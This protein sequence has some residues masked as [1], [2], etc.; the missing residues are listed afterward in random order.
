MSN[1]TKSKSSNG[2]YNTD[3]NTKRIV[4][5]RAAGHCELCGIDLTRDFRAGK[6]MKWGEVAHILP[7]SPKGP[8]G[9]S[10]H[11]E[12]MAEVLTNDSK[13]LMLLCPNCHEKIDRDAEGY[14]E[15]DLNN[16]HQE[17]LERIK[18]AATTPENGRAIPIIVQ[19]HHFST[20]NDI[21]EDDLLSAMSAEGLA[22]FDE[23][24]KIDLTAPIGN[25]RDANYW[26]RHKQEIQDLLGNQLKRRG[27]RF[28]DPPELAVVGV[29][30]IPSLIM[31]GQSL[32]DRSKRSL[33]S[34][35]RG[36]RLKWPNLSAKPPE[37]QFTPPVDGDGPIALVLS[38][39]ALIPHR[40][41][42]AALSG[43]RIAEFRIPEPNYEMV[44]NRK[45]IHAFSHQLQICLSKLEAMSA[46]TIHVFPAIPAALAIEFG[47]L[48]TTQHQHP[49]QIFDRD[50]NKNN[51]F[52]VTLKLGSSSS[53]GDCQ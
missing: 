4:W 31:L 45:V 25:I 18:L 46:D 41:V 21:S 48:L 9:R 38:I 3:E 52:T 13:N 11:N 27:G 10:E 51:A 15:K 34:Y 33:F 2:R 7:A 40:D 36:H 42:E 28:G 17:H 1:Q 22:A 32:G 6:P 53:P 37:F 26:Q 24:I 5:I 50:R 44:Q 23:P 47:A 49:Y 19:G 39:S 14:R 30:D 29:A 16:L 20:K 12:Q 8:R 35:S 43:V